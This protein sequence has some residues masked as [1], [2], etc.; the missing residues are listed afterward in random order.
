MRAIGAA[1]LWAGRMRRKTVDNAV[2][3]APNLA[4]IQFVEN[5]FFKLGGIAGNPVR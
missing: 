4:R 1:A 2:D 5:G 3:S